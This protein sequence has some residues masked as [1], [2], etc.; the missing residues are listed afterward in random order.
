[1]YFDPTTFYHLLTVYRLTLQN[2]GGSATNRTDQTTQAL[3]E[4]F[5]DFQT[6]NGIIFPRHW[7]VHF[8]VIPEP[9]PQLFQWGSKF[10]KASQNTL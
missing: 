1:M 8:H 9:K 3:E 4:R 5:D 7:I 10:S 6:Q 2:A